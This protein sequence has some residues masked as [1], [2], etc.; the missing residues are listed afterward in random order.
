[1]RGGVQEGLLKSEEEPPLLGTA[2]TR[3]SALQ[4]AAAPRCAPRYAL[5]S[6]VTKL[7]RSLPGSRGAD[8]ATRG[9]FVGVLEAI[10]PHLLL[11]F[12][13]ER[14]NM[15]KYTMRPLLH[16]RHVLQY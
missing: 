6:R 8:G 2:G 7:P 10:S 14:L 11:S 13:V 15:D 5:R 12:E 16:A 1:M 4:R 3:W 9:A